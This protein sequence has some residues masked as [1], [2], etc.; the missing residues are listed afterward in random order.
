VAFVVDLTRSLPEPHRVNA[1]VRKPR[2]GEPLQHSGK[3]ISAQKY[4]FKTFCAIVSQSELTPEMQSVTVTSSKSHVFGMKRNLC[5]R[6]G[7]SIEWRAGQNKTANTYV[8]DIATN[9]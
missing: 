9:F 1:V 8:I 3:S 2:A 5:V 4:C 6:N 7:P